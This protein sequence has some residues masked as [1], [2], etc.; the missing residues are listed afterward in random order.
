[1]PRKESSSSKVAVSAGIFDDT[2]YGSHEDYVD[3]L[4]YDVFNMVACDHHALNSA[5]NS[6]IVDAATRATQL[7][8][9]RYVHL[10]YFH[11]YLLL[12][13]MRPLETEYLSAQQNQPI[14]VQ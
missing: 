13:K 12:L 11:P 14:L 7:L 2:G 10:V 4:A 8:I 1:M 3:D 6:V 5:T 9:N